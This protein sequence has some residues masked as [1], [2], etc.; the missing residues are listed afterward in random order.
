MPTRASPMCTQTQAPLSVW[1][2][3]GRIGVDCRLNASATGRTKAPRTER[4]YRRS[5]HISRRTTTHTATETASGRLARGGRP[6]SIARASKAMVCRTQAARVAR[7]ARRCS[8]SSRWTRYARA[9]P[10]A[11]TY[12]MIANVSR[13]WCIALKTQAQREFTTFPMRISS[14]LRVAPR[15]LDERGD[16]APVAGTYGEQIQV[17]R[18]PVF[19]EGRARVPSNPAVE[20]LDVGV[21]LSAGGDEIAL[22][23][24]LGVEA[25]EILR[26]LVAAERALQSRKCPAS[27]A[28]MARQQSLAG[29]RH[30][31][32]ARWGAAEGTN[33]ENPGPIREVPTTVG[34]VRVQHWTQRAARRPRVR[35]APS[36]TRARRRVDPRG[37]SRRYVAQLQKEVESHD[38][39]DSRTRQPSTGGAGV[40]RPTIE[41]MTPGVPDKRPAARGRSG[42]GSE[43]RST[44]RAASRSSDIPSRHQ[45]PREPGPLGGRTVDRDQVA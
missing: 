22:L 13:V 39:I 8:T 12:P 29:L 5:S 2:I 4:P 14:P 33:A 21:T 43:D 18:S 7:E 30:V 11:A 28:Q 35:R 45:R 42:G 20:F 10:V 36:G 23:F 1:P 38:A 41:P 19:D 32:E 9:R 16:R 37:R 25:D 24:L 34:E 27:S 40:S 15:Q 44:P 3:S 26:C 6:R 31:S 17:R